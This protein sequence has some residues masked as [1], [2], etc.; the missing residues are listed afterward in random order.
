MKK[1]NRQTWFFV[2]LGLVVLLGGCQDTDD[3]PGSLSKIS[4]EEASEMGGISDSGIDLCE[5]FE[6]YDDGICDEFCLLPDP[7]CTGCEL[8]GGTCLTKGDDVCPDGVWG[9]PELYSCGDDP[10]VGCCLPTSR[11][12]TGPFPLTD[13][14]N[15]VESEQFRNNVSAIAVADLDA[16]GCL[17]I[18]AIVARASGTEL[19][20]VIA[21]GDPEGKWGERW[22]HSIA[23]EPNNSPG[24]P[25]PFNTRD[26]SSS[27]VSIADF[28][29]N[30]WLDV[31]VASGVAYGGPN[32]ELSWQELPGDNHNFAWPLPA[33]FVEF[34]DSSQI[35]LLRGTVAGDVERCTPESCLALPVAGEPYAVTE[36]AV[37]DFNH[38]G[39]LDVLAGRSLEEDY[40]PEEGLI[41]RSWLW[42]GSSDG[43]GEAS[44]VDGMG[45]VDIEVADMNNNGYL[46][47][48]SQVRE[49]ISDFPSDTD[50]WIS[51]PTGFTK[52]QTIGNND[53]H[54]DAMAVAD[55][56]GDGCP[57]RLFIGVDIPEVA[58]TIGNCNGFSAE[59]LFIP[60]DTTGI[61]VQFIDVNGDNIR[62]I[63]IRAASTTD[64]TGTGLYFVSFT[65]N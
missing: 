1:L 43:F 22:S 36:F 32:R 55:V 16:D 57:D 7:D 63:V 37:G 24:A 35:E 6:W 14:L 10:E 64:G 27:V 20:L 34:S 54:N 44:A 31:G 12:C 60:T 56:N 40:D 2:L 39:H 21:W 51:S 18:A 23:Q 28:N 5:Y 53:N 9:D 4:K 30:G 42:P 38:D 25:P 58:V 59:K 41:V 50:V 3:E 13:R 46:D 49:Y 65:A 29:G 26:S 33:I 11:N 19:A 45:V 8:A 62:E 15:L 17:D 47:V 52:I 48:V 61:G